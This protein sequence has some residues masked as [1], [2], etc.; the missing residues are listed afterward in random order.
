MIRVQVWVR[1]HQHLCL[2][3][4]L[5]VSSQRLAWRIGMTIMMIII[6]PHSRRPWSVKMIRASWSKS[7]QGVSKSSFLTITIRH[8]ILLM[9]F[10]THTSPLVRIISLRQS[11]GKK[12][13]I[14]YSIGE[15]FWIIFPDIALLTTE[16]ERR[17]RRRSSSSSSSWISF[18]LHSLF[19]RNILLPDLPY[20]V[21]MVQWVHN[22]L[23]SAA[24]AG[25]W[26]NIRLFSI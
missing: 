18:S 20:L 17:W 8:I 21:M 2:F 24:K 23:I 25:I 4:D 7:W 6:A 13:I 15:Y 12:I 5:V 14:S 1:D 9:K 26:A 19:P 10:R 3:I 11:A 22:I 16:R